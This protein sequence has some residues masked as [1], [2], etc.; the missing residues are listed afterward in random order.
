MR[1]CSNCVM[2]D[3]KPGVTLDERGWCNACRSA[4]SKK[5]IDWA[6]R[7]QELEKIVEGVR[8]K[9]NPFYDCVVPVSGGKNSWYQ[10]WMMADKFKL[11]VLCVVIG[12]HV[13][14]TEGIHNLNTMVKDL[15]VDTISITL[16]PS[17]YQAIRRKCFLRQGEPNWAEHCAI[18]SGVVNVALMYEVPFIVWGEDIAFEFG[19][20]QTQQ[21]KP[22]A[23]DIDKNDLIK[24]KTIRD[25]LD[26]DISERDV[27]FFSYP[28]HE[29]LRKSGIT[30][31]YLG[32]FDRWEGRKHYE[33]SKS[34]GFMARQQGPLSGNYIDYDNIDEKLCEINIWLK[35]IKFGFWRPTD[36]TC[37]DIWNDKLSR[38]EAVEI[39]NRLQDEFPKE[40]FQDFLRF[41]HI[42]VEE[43]WGTVEKFRNRDIW[44][45]EDGEWKL[46]YP[47]R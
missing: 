31:I 32:H 40:Y 9:N 41:H 1:Y 6:G 5:N 23:I 45:K 36:Q 3:T 35:Y 20:A 42:T 47:L 2:P 37:Y 22:S 24:G 15:N 19:G 43:F 44:K 46:R 25:W 26:D 39:V 33:F 14:T 18:F 10:A 8:A 4:E 27:F 12:A 11:K 29:I 34:R 13:P 16:K 30:S 21:S 7:H 17:V 38:E 28:D